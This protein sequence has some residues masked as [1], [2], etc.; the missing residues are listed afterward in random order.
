MFPWTHSQ[1]VQ[2]IYT[3]NIRSQYILEYTC[4]H[5]KFNNY[6]RITKNKFGHIYNLKHIKPSRFMAMASKFSNVWA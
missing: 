2:S 5:I 1:Y 3:V 4:Q 6:S